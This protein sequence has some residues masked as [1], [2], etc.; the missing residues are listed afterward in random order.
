MKTKKLYLFWSDEINDFRY[1]AGVAFRE[2]EFGE[3]R[4]KVDSY[5]HRR[6]YLKAVN[7]NEGRIDYR[8][9]EVKKI[10]NDIIRCQAGFG[11]GDKET[12]HDV[13]IHIV[14]HLGE[15]LILSFEEDR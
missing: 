15:K 13:V 1:I 2:E 10:K 5:P 4:L 6:L 9:D 12:N 14:P 7:T 3:Y 8:V 11:Y